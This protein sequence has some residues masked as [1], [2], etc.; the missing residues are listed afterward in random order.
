DEQRGYK[1]KAVFA[2]IDFDLIPKVL[3]ATGGVRFYHY[4]EFEHG[5]EFY[6]EST[7]PLVVNH[8]NGAC[9]AGGAC[10]FPINLDKSESGHRLRGNLSYHITPDMMAYY[11]YSEGFRP[12]GFNRTSSLLGQPPT[13][14]GVAT[15]CGGPISG[16]PQDKLDPRCAAGGSLFGLN[17]NQFNKPAGYSSDNLINNEIG[18]KSEFFE[19]RLVVNL[20]GYI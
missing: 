10:G 2:S 14:K 4:D 7:S 18:F 13:L 12:G 19:H 8:A 9:P 5:S 6:S 20:S 16:V 3:T 11:T 15:Y 17:T 1:Q